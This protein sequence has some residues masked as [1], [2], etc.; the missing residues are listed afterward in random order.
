MH[1][2]FMDVILLYNGRQHV[3]ATHVAPFR[4]VCLNYSTVLK[5]Y[6]FGSESQLNNKMK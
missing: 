2:G 3:L 1:F 6:S 5:S 4:V